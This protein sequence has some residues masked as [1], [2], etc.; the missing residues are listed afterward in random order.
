MGEWDEA[1]DQVLVERLA[2]QPDRAR[3]EAFNAVY[4]RY[5][6]TMLYSTARLPDLDFERAESIAA[7]AFTQAY[8]DLTAGRGPREADKLGP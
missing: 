3:E 1:S 7:E 5:H 2:G 6:R 8:K 4:L